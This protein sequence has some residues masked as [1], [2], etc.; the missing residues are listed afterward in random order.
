MDVDDSDPFASSAADSST[1][2]T[3]AHLFDAS[4]ASELFATPDYTPSNG[5][6]LSFDATPTTTVSH[7]LFDAV[8]IGA[9]DPF[10]IGVGASAPVAND[11]AALF[12]AP[13]V[14]AGDDVTT[15]FAAPAS[16]LSAAS[17]FESTSSSASSFADAS[18]LFDSTPAIQTA[19]IAAVAA[20]ASASPA[21]SSSSSSSSSSST[22]SNKP[23]VAEI[24]TQL[25]GSEDNDPFS[26]FGSPSAASSDPFASLGTSP[27]SSVTAAAPFAPPQLAQQYQPQPFH[28]LQPQPQVAPHASAPFAVKPPTMSVMQ[29]DSS[30]LYLSSPFGIASSPSPAPL[31]QPI[32]CTF[33]LFSQ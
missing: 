20:S 3:A 6:A 32:A 8:P 23:A 29:P 24:P 13:A 7:E 27:Y 15:A 5:G 2:P 9:S 30:P 19:D 21:A 14:L 33:L 10:D 26:S 31:E 22:T 25:F 11:A 18:S 28:A 16:P 4:P 12:D 17:L 1:A